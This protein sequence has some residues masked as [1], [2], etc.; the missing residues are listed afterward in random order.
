MTVHVAR[1]G[2][3]D[4]AAPLVVLLHGRGG[5]VQEILT[6]AGLLPASFAYA[7]V[8]APIAEGRE[9]LGRTWDYLTGDS[10]A[11][12]LDRR[13]PVGHGLAAPAVEALAA[14]LSD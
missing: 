1:A 14:W 11:T 7:S 6:L 5:G 4:P 2:S 10:G 9:L 12:T 8:R 13:D 3:D